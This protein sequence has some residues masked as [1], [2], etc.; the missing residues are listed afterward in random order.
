M[1]GQNDENLPFIRFPDAAS[2]ERHHDYRNTGFCCE[3]GFVLHKL[4]EKEPTLYARLDDPHPVIRIRGVDIPLNATTFNEALV[5]P[6]VLN[7][8]Y[9]ARIREMDLEWLRDTLV[10]PTRQDQVYWATVEGITITDW[11]PNSKR[12]LHLVTRRIRPSSNCIDVTFPRA[13]VVACA[14]QGIPL[15]E[16]GAD[17]LRMEDILSGQQNG[18]LSSWSYHCP[19]QAGGSATFDA[20]E[21]L[22]MD[23]PLHPLLVRT[24]STSRGKRRRTGSASSSK[25]VLNSDDD[26]PLSDARVE[27]DL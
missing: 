6:E 26:D 15:N 18:A 22:S 23:P 24:G 2:R 12:W 27:E 3:R 21:V 7:H 11:S 19:V 13:L 16:G 17:H 20:D 10:E 5:V 25:A 9:E 4:E 14:I 1:V 8:K